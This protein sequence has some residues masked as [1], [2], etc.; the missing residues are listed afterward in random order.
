MTP[1]LFQPTVSLN[2]SLLAI[3]AS[4]MFVALAITV[5]SVLHQV[6]QEAEE[7][8]DAR[9]IKV[10]EDLL[11]QTTTLMRYDLHNDAWL[12]LETIRG[13]ENSW[14]T[15]FESSPALLFFGKKSVTGNKDDIKAYIWV[16]GANGNVVLGTPMP[17][18][19]SNVRED[20]QIASF[21]RADHEWRIA[22]LTNEG[23][24][25]RIYWA[26][27]DDLRN[28]ISR[29]VG[30]QM[31]MLQLILI[32][33]VVLA[34]WLGIRRALSPLSRISRQISNRRSDDLQPVALHEVPAEI[35]PVVQAINDL[36]KRL[37][38]TLESERSFTANAAHELRNPLAAIRN[39]T[40]VM[41]DTEDLNDLA[42][43]SDLLDKSVERMADLLSQ[44]LHLAKLDS[45]TVDTRSSSTA[46]RGIVEDAVSAFV[47]LALEKSMEITYEAGQEVSI[48]GDKHLL[49]M[50]FSN[51]LSNSVKYGSS[52]SNII[53][54]VFS[55]GKE[56]V[57]E[58]LDDGPGVASQRL[59]HLFERFYRAAENQNQAPGTGLG[60]AIVKRIAELH[61]AEIS[62]K[63]RKGGGLQ[64]TLRLPHE[65]WEAIAN[66]DNFDRSSNQPT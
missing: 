65:R 1:R 33:M 60:L 34:L 19:A 50:M 30:N 25:L 16:T 7:V 17:D 64:I 29:D 47:P 44:L 51:L 3:L 57:I 6:D 15:E 45:T 23:N 46:L 22:S 5:Y 18:Y 48:R 54:R 28:Y 55:Q 42:N 11:R 13:L 20:Q 58:V 26:Q 9:Q 2:R 40:R 49:I 8:L 62:A 21:E 35:L 37:R 27:R 66:T 41:G 53:I 4:A 56:L 12:A 14:L 59:P 63:N 31:M 38:I 36:L 39:I 24:T 32:P 61:D 43:N 52:S 10:A